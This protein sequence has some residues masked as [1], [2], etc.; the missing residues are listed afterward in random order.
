[1]PEQESAIANAGA[2]PEAPGLFAL[3]PALRRL[4]ALL[5]RLVGAQ[6]ADVALRGM[7]V[8]A[9]EA[10]Q[11]L[12][13]EPCAP[14]FG[15][16]GDTGLRL[17]DLPIDAIG[18]RFGLS[19]FDLDAVLIALA[20]EFDLRYERLYGFLH[21]DV[22]RRRATVDLVLNLR[23]SSVEEKMARLAHFAPNAPL[24]RHAVVHLITDPNQ[25]QPPLLAHYVKVDDQ[26]IGAL[27]GRTGLRCPARR[28]LLLLRSG[29]ELRCLAV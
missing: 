26:I 6:K 13:R 19:A 23:T 1:M 7:Y 21:D 18:R 15:F 2:L 17:E 5:D 20:P 3:R 14:T 8:S 11:L 12:V 4:D 16:A 22:T 24:I 10:A 27:L 25:I 28:F 9:E 29:P